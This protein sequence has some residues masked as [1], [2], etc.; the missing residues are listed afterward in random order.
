MKLALLGGEK[1]VTEKRAPFSL[2]T[3]KAYE[4]TN[5]MMNAGDISIS[6]VFGEFEERFA[7]YIGVKY[8][9]CF[10][11]GTTAIQSALFAVGVGAGDEVI[12]PSFTFWA[13]VGSVLACNAIPV[14]ADV[15]LDSQTLT[16]EHIEKVITPKTKA[17][18]AVHTW[19]T[20]CEIEPIIDLAKKYNIKVIEDCSHAHGAVYHSKKVGSFGD[21]GCFSL[22][23]SKVLAAGEGGIMVTN[24]REYYE[25]SC[26][27]GHYERLAKFDDDSLYK[28][29]SG[30]G[31]GYKHRA[32]PLGIAIANAGLDVLDERNDI[33]YNNGKLLDSMLSDLEFLIPQKS[34]ENARRVYAYHY[35]RYVPEKLGNL[36]LNV[37][38]KALAAEG[39]LGGRCGYGR[40]HTA[41]FVTD[42][43]MFGNGCPLSCPH[44]AES[45]IPDASLP[46]TESLAVNSLMVAPRFENESKECIEQYA[47]AY[48]KISENVEE[49]LEYEALLSKEEKAEKQTIGR[50]INSF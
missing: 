50:S 49:L 30:T 43:G 28:K 10:C 6:P 31:L 7:S 16:A 46:N 1:A 48:H 41:P 44:Y 32:H 13:T 17:I 21:I 20:P 27:L 18:V 22:Q 12:V 15:D 25:R 29:F 33:R 45:Y 2:V 14:F 23:G 47:A 4:T 11:N 42:G 34:P 19:G 38:C 5:A 35:M 24:N 40:L 9:L 3:Q 8:G 37:L 36:S 26:A 39:V